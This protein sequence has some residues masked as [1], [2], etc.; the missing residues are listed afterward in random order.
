MTPKNGHFD[1]EFTPEDRKLEALLSLALE[2]NPPADLAARV[3]EASQALLD[4]NL[5][6][7]LD[8]ALACTPPEHLASKVF[9]SSVA[10]LHQ[11]P[12]AVIARVKPSIAW[13]QLALAA[14]LMFAALVAIR[15]GPQTQLQTQPQ[16][17]PFT[18]ALALLSVEDEELFLEDS[19]YAYL[20]GTRELAFADVAAS[21]NSLRNDVEMWQNGLLSE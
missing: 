9:D 20:A 8:V 5:E 13:Q 4:A 1:Q 18:A 14:C 19:G 21:F 11:E 15:V 17:Q 16:S 7:Q 2:V 6:Q 12:I 10:L 3:A